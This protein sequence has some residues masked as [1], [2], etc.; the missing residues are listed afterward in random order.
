MTFYVC[1]EGRRGGKSVQV[2]QINAFQN[3]V[4]GLALWACSAERSK[5][6]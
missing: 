3:V 5:Q 1:S 4:Q 2:N 6:S